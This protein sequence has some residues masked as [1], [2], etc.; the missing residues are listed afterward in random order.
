MSNKNTTKELFE[1]HVPYI[2]DLLEQHSYPWEAIR[3]IKTYISYL[4][5]T[6]IEGFTKIKEGVLVGSN[7][8]IADN[9]L[10]EA[11][12]IIGNSC[13]IR[14]GAYLRG[15]I[16]TG[17]N[18]VI[19]NSTEIKNSILLNFVQVPHYNYVGDSILGNYTHMGAGAICSNLKADKKEIIIHAD[20]DYKTDMR[21]IGAILGDGVEIGCNCVLNP[22]TIIGKNTTVYPLTSVRGVIP[23]NSIMKS[24]SVIELKK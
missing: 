10:I 2:N 20:E 4:L 16:I 18:C 11:P 5:I 12:S 13:E 19:G 15:N 22:G 21:K 7:V 23:E 8:K 17:E 1:C 9:V 14:H 3:D 24:S 6:G